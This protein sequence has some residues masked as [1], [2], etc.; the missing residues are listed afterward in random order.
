MLRS[1]LPSPPPPYLTDL[2]KIPVL[3]S[4]AGGNDLEWRLSALRQLDFSVSSGVV[5]DGFFLTHEHTVPANRRTIGSADEISFPSKTVFELLPEICK[6]LP[7]HLPRFLTGIWQPYDIAMAVKFGV[8]L[9]DG[10]FPY[11]LSRSAVAWIYPGWIS[12]SQHST[13]EHF[14][15]F[16]LA[17][18]LP[19]GASLHTPIQPGCECSA[20]ARYTRLYISHL[21]ITREILGAMLLMIHNSHQF[22][23]FFEDIRLA[24]ERDRMDEFILFS[25]S[26]CI[27]YKLLTVDRTRLITS[28]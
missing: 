28:N 9:F 3:L 13:D 27:P 17:D 26:L 6:H 24:A 4:L 21:H 20:C 1:L 14:I 7:T 5:L 22:Y 16:P 19:N 10:S 15:V 8:D 12:K 18:V 25:K 11:R 2:A 23:R